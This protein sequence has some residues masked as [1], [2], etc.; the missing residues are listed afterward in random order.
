MADAKPRG[1]HG[2]CPAPKILSPDPC[3]RW[4]EAGQKV[5]P[6]HEGTDPK[7]RCEAEAGRPPKERARCHA[8]PLTGAAF[9]RA[10]DPAAKAERQAEKESLA[11]QLAQVR[12]LVTPH[13]GVK[14]LELLV[15]RRKVSVAD[16]A[17]VLAEYR[18]GL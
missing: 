12:K 8:W 11:Y 10:H 17:Q 5:C 15:L 2:T 7:R 3:A 6:A 1:P 16:V 14:A 13:V 18:V 9:C 4:L